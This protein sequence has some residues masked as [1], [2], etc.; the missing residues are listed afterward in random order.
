MNA[1]YWNKINPTE[2]KSLEPKESIEEFYKNRPNLIPYGL[3]NE[4]GHFNVFDITEQASPKHNTTT[5]RRKDFYKIKMLTGHFK[6]HY[7]DK[8][9]EIDGT[10]LIFVH[11]YIPYHFEFIDPEVTGYLCIF[12]EDFFEHFNQIKAYPIYQPGG[13]PCFKIEPGE[14]NT[15]RQ[16]YLQMQSEIRSGYAFKYDLLRN[17]LSELMHKAM[18]LRPADVSMNRGTNANIRI[19]HLFTELLELQFP[20]DTPQQ[21]I[22]LRTAQDFAGQLSIHINH[23]NRAIRQTTGKTTTQ[24]IGERLMLEARALLKYTDWNI[25]EI[26]YSLGFED[27]SYFIRSFKSQTETTP[28]GFRKKAAGK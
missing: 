2:M 5:Y 17:Y 20:V 25:S 18:K 15:F 26:G 12:K 19:Y 22:R 21:A 28:K 10:A 9:I 7:A 16:L 27:T 8:S 4:L 3:K 6:F 13:N 11:P 14:I 23:L 1:F 24:L